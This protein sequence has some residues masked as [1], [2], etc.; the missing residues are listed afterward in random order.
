MEKTKMAIPFN[1]RVDDT[2]RTRLEW[3]RYYRSRGWC[4]LPLPTGEKNPKSNGKGWHTREYDD[5]CFEGE[6]N[7]GTILKDNTL[8]V[9]LDATEAVAVAPY[10]LPPTQLIHGRASKPRSHWWY[11]GQGEMPGG[12]QQFRDPLDSAMLVE[13]RATDSAKGAMTV[14]PPSIHPS[15]EVVV[16]HERGE[17]GAVAIS[18][19]HRHVAL[20]AATALL[21]RHWPTHSRHYFSLALAGYLLNG[22]VDIDTACTVVRAAAESAGDEEADARVLNVETTA[23]N[24]ARGEHVTGGPTLREHLDARVVD[25]LGKWLNLRASTSPH[26]ALSP[27][28]LFQAQAM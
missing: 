1:R 9:D 19:L 17:P 6:G 24:I 15:G 27:Q 16:W 7:L 4:P 22:G 26:V 28:P 20:V 12:V 8:D 14:V 23:G 13:L 10:F 25:A 3:A 21:A 2:P 5:D 18:A 11:A